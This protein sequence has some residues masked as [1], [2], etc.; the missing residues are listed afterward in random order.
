MAEEVKASKLVSA[1]KNMSR[2]FRDI[3]S[4]LKKVIWP[5]RQQLTN[6]TVTVL[7]ACL[8]TGVIIWI[9]DLVL[10]GVLRL[11]LNNL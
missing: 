2:S 11:L 7:A 8:V 1:R 9:A 10:G 6:N 5:T 4:E 3:K